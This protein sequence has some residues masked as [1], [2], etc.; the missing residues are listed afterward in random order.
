MDAILELDKSDDLNDEPD[1]PSY[2]D[3]G[4][5]SSSDTAVESLGPEETSLP[6]QPD[7]FHHPLVVRIQMGDSAPPAMF[8]TSISLGDQVQDVYGFLARSAFHNCPGSC[9]EPYL[10]D[11]ASGRLPSLPVIGGWGEIRQDLYG[12]DGQHAEW[13]VEFENLELDTPFIDTLRK[14]RVGYELYSVLYLELH[15]PIAKCP[16]GQRTRWKSLYGFWCDSE[17]DS[18]EDSGEEDEGQEGEH[19]H[20]RKPKHEDSSDS[21]SSSS[22][23]PSPS[24]SSR[25]KEKRPHV[26]D[27]TSDGMIRYY[28]MPLH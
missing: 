12:N 10:L 26:R 20:Q 27:D 14:R 1:D 22:S 7:D 24:S 16:P 18:E 2:S 23:D 6:G 9:E 15:I 5:D 25:K 3:P 17:E 11:K 8:A 13:E 4:S 21:P 19:K 28:M